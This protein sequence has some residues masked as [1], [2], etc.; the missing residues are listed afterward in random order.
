MIIIDKGMIHSTINSST[1]QSGLYKVGVSNQ[2]FDGYTI[3]NCYG[4]YLE[5]V[6]NCTFPLL[7]LRNVYSLNMRNCNNNTFKKVF[8]DDS[9]VG[10]K[11][12]FLCS[13]NRFEEVISTKAKDLS[14]SAN[15]DG[16]VIYNIYFF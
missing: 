6:H 8:I 15:G 9:W 11:L 7:D 1:R 12:N 16:I 13:N 2:G 4:V 3:I 10:L 5:N 14:T